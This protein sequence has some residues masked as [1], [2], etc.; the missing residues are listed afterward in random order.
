[1][2][3]F[4]SLVEINLI[5]KVWQKCNMQLDTALKHFEEFLCCLDDYRRNGFDSALVT[6]IEIADEMDMP[7]KFKQIG[8]RKKKYICLRVQCNANNCGNYRGITLLSTASKLYANILRNKFNKYTE[9]I[10]G[11]DQ[12]GFRT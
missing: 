5:S 1:M 8:L 10:L 4:R 9:E 11:E 3:P 7:R 2:A 12:C 6:A